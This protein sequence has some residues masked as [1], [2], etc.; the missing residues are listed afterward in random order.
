[1]LKEEKK[2]FFSYTEENPLTAPSSWQ[3][4]HNMPL[5]IY[6][7]VS[8]SLW[9]MEI[10][11]KPKTSEIWSSICHLIFHLSL[12]PILQ[13]TGDWMTEQ[14]DS[15]G[16][17]SDGQMLI[18]TPKRD[19]SNWASKPKRSR[20]LQSK[21]PQWLEDTSMQIW[22]VHHLILPP[23]PRVSPDNRIRASRWWNGEDTRFRIRKARLEY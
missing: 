21:I 6:Q 22:T 9:T 23:R 19:R 15:R 2:C 10:R 14:E 20:R 7:P 12:P 18:R 4:D 11:M 13:R 5:S 1:M 17:L 16:S 3:Q 8:I